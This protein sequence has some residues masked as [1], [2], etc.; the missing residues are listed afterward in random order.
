MTTIETLLYI[1]SLL[2]LLLGCSLPYYS[3]IAMLV[4]I[5]SLEDQTCFKSMNYT[6]HFPRYRVL[7]LFY[8]VCKLSY[9]MRIP[10]LGI[11]TTWAKFNFD[12]CHS[13]IDAFFPDNARTS[14]CSSGFR[15][16]NLKLKCCVA[17]RKHM[18][19]WKWS[20]VS[21][22]MLPTILDCRLQTVAFYPN[23]LKHISQFCYEA[24]LRG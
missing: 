8:K 22:E 17:R 2:P 14:Y 16:L 9:Q 1:P 18:S 13:Q 15:N 11:E 4:S 3:H 19:I 12:I 7:R 21:L 24:V 10:V 6:I 5:R 20:F 23:E